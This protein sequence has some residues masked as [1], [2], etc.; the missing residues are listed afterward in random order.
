MFALIPVLHAA[1]HTTTFQQQQNFLSL[2][3]L[4]LYQVSYMAV[5]SI[6]D[7]Q[8]KTKTVKKEIA[9]NYHSNTAPY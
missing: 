8:N 5:P 6:V 1:T 4:H 9:D 2:Y 3:I 7:Y